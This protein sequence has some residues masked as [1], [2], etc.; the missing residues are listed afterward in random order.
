MQVGIEFL[1]QKGLTHYYY[2]EEFSENV[3]K[4]GKCR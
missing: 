3:V 2:I 4:M 1:V